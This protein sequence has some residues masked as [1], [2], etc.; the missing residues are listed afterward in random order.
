[1]T[2]S[3]SSTYT[4]ADVQRWIQGV[5][6]A[7]KTG[8]LEDPHLQDEEFRMGETN[9]DLN[10]KL[11]IRQG[12]LKAQSLAIKGHDDE[13]PMAKQI[14]S[15]LRVD[16]QYYA[17][18]DTQPTTEWH[19]MTEETSRVIWRHLESI[20]RLEHENHR[21]SLQFPGLQ[22]AASSQRN[23]G[24]PAQHFE[25]SPPSHQESQLANGKDVRSGIIGTFKILYQDTLV[26]LAIH[27]V[28]WALELLPNGKNTIAASKPVHTSAAPV[29]SHGIRRRYSIVVAVSCR[30][31]CSFRC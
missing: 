19:R 1:M 21:L 25:I 20:Q 30:G 3:T 14:T 28:H 16:N 5:E 11:T 26:R 6:S 9:K 2:K 31:I 4:R 23:I 24:H 29:S 12:L 10:E 13:L 27:G 18:I 22:Q 8:E 17:I 7:K 15:D